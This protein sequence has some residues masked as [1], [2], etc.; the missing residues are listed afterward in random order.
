MG[1]RHMTREQ[2]QM[3][4]RLKAKGLTLKVIARVINCSVPLVTASVYVQPP[5]SGLPDRWTPA[6]GRLTAEECRLTDEPFVGLGASTDGGGYYEAGITGAALGFG[7]VTSTE[8]SIGNV[9]LASLMTGVAV[10]STG[11]GAWFVGSDGGVFAVTATGG[12]QP[13]FL[14]SLPGEGIRPA[15]PIVGIAA[16]HDDLGYWLV[17]ADGGVVS[18]GDAGF[19]GSA[20]GSGLPW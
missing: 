1:V 7:D 9:T 11:G 15:A 17:G 20:G 3:A 8:M 6:P 4:R 5:E 18:F 14:G 13:P 2:K 10:T 12:T 16:T 19:Y